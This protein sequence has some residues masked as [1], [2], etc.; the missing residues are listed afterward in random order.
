MIVQFLCGM[1]LEFLPSSEDVSQLN[2]LDIKKLR[3]LSTVFCIL[4]DNGT[5]LRQFG[6]MRD[7]C[8]PMGP[9]LMKSLF[10]LMFWVTLR[11]WIRER[12]DQSKKILAPPQVT[13]E[14]TTAAMTQ[15][16][17]DKKSSWKR[18]V[19]FF[20][21]FLVRFWI[22]IVATMLFV[23]GISGNDV[24]VFRIGY[25]MLFLVFITVFHVSLILDVKDLGTE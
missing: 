17:K 10:T 11:Q 21:D 16:D 23:L 20:H 6:F 5:L 7:P 9:L 24:T 19:K 8:L 4:Q 18:V 25:M 13:L 3:L 12:Q 22:W 14:A 1:H 2:H 15:S